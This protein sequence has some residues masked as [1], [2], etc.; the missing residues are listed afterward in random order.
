MK[1]VC[2]KATFVMFIPLSLCIVDSV[3]L[4]FNG[5]LPPCGRP[6]Y[7]ASYLRYSAV[8]TIILYTV[9]TCGESDHNVAQLES[10]RVEQ[11]SKYESGLF[12]LRDPFSY[13]GTVVSVS[14]SGY[15]TVVNRTGNQRFEVRLGLYDAESR[16]RVETVILPAECITFNESTDDSVICI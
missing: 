9:Q 6:T 8:S 14:A 5:T 15:C 10:C 13:S 7:I 11:E 12:L 1:Q 16:D 4:N 2:L 3:T